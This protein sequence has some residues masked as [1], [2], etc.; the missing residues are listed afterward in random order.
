LSCSSRSTLRC[1]SPAAGTNGYQDPRLT[2]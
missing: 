2:L 1:W